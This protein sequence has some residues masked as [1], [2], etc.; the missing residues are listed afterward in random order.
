MIRAFIPALILAHLP[1]WAGVGTLEVG[2]VTREYRLTVP[3]SAPTMA[4]GAPLVVA[5]HGMG[6]DSPKLMQHYTRLDETAGTHGF[7]IAYPSA[8]DGHWGLAPAKVTAD[9]AFFDALVKAISSAHRIDPS[10]VFV[11]GM[12][13]GGYFAHLVGKERS[14]TVA[15]V[16]SHSGP[17]GL[18]ALGGIGAARKFPVMIIH[19]EADRLFPVEIARENRDKY[20]RERHPVD[21]V[22]IPGLGHFWG[23]DAG[24]NEKIWAFFSANPLPSR[25]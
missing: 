7:L 13:N 11:L 9:L 16:A 12:S 6:I 25:Q 20:T 19:G 15:A 1:A 14:E 22:E 23:T 10:R 4:P 5:F 2:G 17:L 18:Q 21:Y 8:I 3:R 24:I